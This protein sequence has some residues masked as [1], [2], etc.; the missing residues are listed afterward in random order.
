MRMGIPCRCQGCIIT[1]SFMKRTTIVS[2]FWA[3]MGFVAGKPRPLMVKPPSA[4]LLIQTMSCGAPP[5]VAGGVVMRVVHVRAGGLRHELI[6]K[7]L[8]GHVR[9]LRH[10]RHAVHGVGDLLAV[11]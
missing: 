6:R 8:A 2:P 5:G 10:E 9:L 11:E 1:P 7:G 4:A 3:T